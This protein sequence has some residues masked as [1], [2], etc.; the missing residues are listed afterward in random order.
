[1]S[2]LQKGVA[3]TGQRLMRPVACLC[4]LFLM[5]GVASNAQDVADPDRID[6]V[7]EDWRPYSYQEAGEIKGSATEIVLKTVEEAGLEYQIA[8][9][10]WVRG[11]KKT[12]SHK[13]TLIS[14]SAYIRVFGCGAIRKP[15]RTKIP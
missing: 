14:A 2:G 5:C 7:T 15:C 10:P 3:L 9:Y 8:V 13:N 12:L 6:I 11:Y 1:M 4:V